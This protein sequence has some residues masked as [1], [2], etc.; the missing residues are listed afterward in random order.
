MNAEAN[1]APATAWSPLRVTVFRALF[2]AALVSNIGTWMHEVGAAW[3]MTSLTSSPLLVALLGTASSLPLFLFALPAGAVGDLVDKRKYLLFTQ[4][5]MTVVAGVLGAVT[6]FGWM[7]PWLLLALTCALG[8]G[9]AMNQP[10]WQAIVPEIVPREEL[11]KA[12]TLS[13]VS[14]NLARAI[15]PAAAGLIL[16][17]TSPG[18]VFLINA[19]SFVAVLLVLYRWERTPTGS[20][21]PAEHAGSAVRAGLRYLRHAPDFQA[22]LMRTG[23]FV[24]SASAVWALLPL[25]G[26]QSLGLD[27]LGYGFLV[28]ALGTG[29][30][31]MAM[32]LPRVRARLSVDQLVWVA[33]AAFA[34]VAF[35]LAFVRVAALVYLA[36]AVAGAAW[37]S[38]MSSFNVASQ[39]MSASWVRSRALA[40]YSIA[41]QGGL[42]LG[43]ALWGTVASRFGIGTA[44][45]AAGVGLLVGLA[46][47]R[48]FPLTGRD[49][50]DLTPSLHWPQP[51][52]VPEARPGDGPVLVV[53]EY[54][55]S[56]EN[57]E[58]FLEA[59]HEMERVR[60]RDGGMEWSVYQDAADHTRYVETFLAES[61][62]EHLRQHQRVTM[63]DREIER[64]IR[65][66]CIEGQRGRVLHLLH[67]RPP[68]KKRR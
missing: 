18:I 31:L 11:A 33:T 15:G 36:M 4:A 29:A 60:R 21:L 16:A 2:F 46:A 3:L 51:L 68:E 56:P 38:T 40:A 12:I 52:L 65:S 50:R 59:V 27:S 7:T 48:A 62:T 67:V 23:L 28:G 66:F 34:G 63:A 47:S 58:P 44:L 14:L 54:W 61:W 6:L 5:W 1:L 39:L 43:S 53:I 49:D 64:R 10:V 42:A 25:V 9:V 41:F 22:V 45:T 13:G 57:A 24:L 17:A 20:G 19:A 32:V 55:V 30:V 8:I 26:R 37:I 35:T